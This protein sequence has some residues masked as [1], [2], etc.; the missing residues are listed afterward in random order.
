MTTQNTQPTNFQKSQQL[1]F[2]YLVAFGVI[3]AALTWW[4]P[5]KKAFGTYYTMAYFINAT[6]AA[7]LLVYSAPVWVKFFKNV[8]KVKLGQFE[9]EM[10]EDPAGNSVIGNISDGNGNN[11]GS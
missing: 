11:I 9:M 3:F 6:A 8:K 5:F 4:D 10:K 7:C 2:T 1:S